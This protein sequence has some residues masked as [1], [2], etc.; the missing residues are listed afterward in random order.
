MSKKISVIIPCY[1]MEKYIVKCLDTIVGQSYENLEIII[2]NDGSTDDT[3]KLIGKYLSD[4]RVKYINQR[5]AGVSAARNTGIEAAT[6]EWLTFVDCDDYLEL[7]MYKKLYAAQENS[8]A[9]VAVCNYNLIYDK[10]TEKQYSKPFDETVNIRD[11]VYGYFAQFCACPKP[12]NYIWD[13]LYKAD[14]IKK[15]GVRFEQYKLGDDTLFNFKLLPHF[16]RVVFIPEGLYNYFQRGNSNVYTIANKTNLA[17]EYA[18]TFQSLVDYYR[19]NHF[20]A[21]FE[22]LPMHAFTRLRSI[23]FYSR[24]AG[25]NDDEIITNI[26]TAFRNRDIYKYLTGIKL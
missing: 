11:N 17:Q 3:P 19:Q 12:N 5:N 24:L 20:D 2:V 22:V 16:N 23:F 26:Q 21:F 6:G 18:D 9:D 4:K 25:Q 13:K 7:D 8:N 15:S 14:I 1:N 10:Y